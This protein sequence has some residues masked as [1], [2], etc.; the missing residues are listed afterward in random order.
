LQAAGN[1]IG[2]IGNL[3][4]VT[5]AWAADDAE[6]RGR[7]RH[8]CVSDLSS[9]WITALSFRGDA[10]HRTRNLEMPDL[11]LTHHP[12]MTEVL[13]RLRK[14]RR[15]FFYVRTHRLG[16]VGAAE[17]FLLLDGFGEQRRRWIDGQL[18]QH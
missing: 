12:G 9:G 14:P 6:E 10:Q 17:Q 8:Y 16:L 5:L 4:M 13:P 11:V 7:G 2:A 3:R 15:A 1:A 18:V